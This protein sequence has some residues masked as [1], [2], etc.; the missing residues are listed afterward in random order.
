M[1]YLRRIANA[2]YD[3]L[4]HLRISVVESDLQAIRYDREN[5][6][7][8]FELLDAS[9]PS[10]ILRDDIEEIRAAM[11]E[12][13]GIASCLL[14]LQIDLERYDFLYPL[15]DLRSMLTALMRAQQDRKPQQ[16]RLGVRML[17]EAVAL[18]NIDGPIAA[19]RETFAAAMASLDDGDSG[20]ARRQLKNSANLI[21]LLNVG[22]YVTEGLWHLARANHALGQR[23]FSIALASLKKADARLEDAEDRAWSEYAAA[24][25]SVR[26]DLDEVLTKAADRKLKLTLKATQLK[27]VAQRIDRELRIPY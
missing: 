13:G 26:E 2:T 12:D 18:P 5:C 10:R 17:E 15:A 19:S 23:Q 25:S 21:S 8:L 4:L 27:A 22:A 1:R 14:G 7:L 3:W 16:V 24:V 6:E 20:E 11:E 9:N